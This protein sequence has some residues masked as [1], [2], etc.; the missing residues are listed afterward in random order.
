MKAAV[1]DN[2]GD[3]KELK[4][5]DIDKPE[6]AAGQLLVKVQA[7]NVNPI[8]WKI[9]EGWM[10]MRYGEEFPMI[11]GWDCS[12]VVEAIGDGVAGFKV[13]DE[14]FARSDVGT[15]K[16]YAEYAVI[17]TS[18]AVHKPKTLSHQEAGAIPLTGLTA[19]NSLINCAKVKSGQRVLIIGGSGGVGTLAIQIAKNLGAHVTAVC[20]TNNVALVKSLGADQ[21][22][23]YTLA[24]PLSCDEPYDVI[25]DTVCAH[26]YEKARQS[27]KESGVFLTLSPAPG[28]DFF[29]PGQTELEAG[30]GYFIAWTPAAADLQILA[31]WADSGQLKVIIDSVYTLDEIQAAHL[32]SQT[33]RCVG[34]IVINVAGA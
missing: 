28:V 27:L 32:R 9:R 4:I 5:R 31:D 22:I 10:A 8:D 3:A 21:V 15:G 24:D 30:K 13:G 18:T 1:L 33:E 6:P 29:I 14:V 16:C 25:Y 11:L 19:I 17:N 12:G 2:F 7:T 20:S 23:D 26:E 34:K